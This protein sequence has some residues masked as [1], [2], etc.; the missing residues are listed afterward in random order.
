V[1]Q[2]I[3]A[4]AAQHPY[5]EA[6]SATAE[7]SHRF[8]PEKPSGFNPTLDP[9]AMALAKQGREHF[10]QLCFACHGVDGKGVVSNDGM[11]MGPPLAGS[12]RVLGNKE[13]VTRIVLD[14]L[15]GELDGKTYA[16]FMLPMKANDD[17]WLAEVLTYIRTSFGNSASAIT[18]E[19]VARV[20]AATKDR[21]APY[22]LAELGDLVPVSPEQMAKWTFSA[23]HNA[24]AAK[25]AVDGDAGSRWDT[26]AG[27]VA[28]QWFQFDM[29][30]PWSLSQLAV[31]CNGSA[32]DYPRGWEI[33]LSDD[34]QKWSEPIA[35]G[36]GTK[37]LLEIPFPKGTSARYVRLIQTASGKTGLFWSIHELA[38]CGAEKK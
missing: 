30:K 26:G 1:K 18:K 4:I 13:A 16:G 33:R 27:Q 21:A 36:E 23:S 8:D 14:G 25:K 15:L 22:T 7:Q 12:A 3:L 19:D 11:R 9:V 10:T 5:N 37:P 32:N 38:V 35:K 34:G 29:G 28:G 6:I 24:A 17:Q 31:E 20:R 2:L